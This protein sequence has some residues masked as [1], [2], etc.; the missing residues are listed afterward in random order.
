MTAPGLDAM[1]PRV[2]DLL[3][4]TYFFNAEFMQTEA[5]EEHK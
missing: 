5:Y 1:S 4:L 3:N 2:L